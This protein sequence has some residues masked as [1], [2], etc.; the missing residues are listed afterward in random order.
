[1]SDDRDMEL[2]TALRSLPT[3]EHEPAFWA[4]LD[5]RLAGELPMEPDARAVRRFRPRGMWL[6]TAAAVAAVAVAAVAVI[7]GGTGTNVRVGPPATTPPTAPWTKLSQS[8][9]SPRWG[10]AAV[11]TGDAMVVWGGND[12]NAQTLEDGAVYDPAT[13]RWTSMA[14]APTGLFAPTAVW[15]GTRALF[16]G[17]RE[18]QGETA[19][20]A[21]VGALYDPVADTW[22]LIS[23]TPLRSVGQTVVWTGDALLVW[24]GSIGESPVADGAAYHPDTDTWTTMARAPIP[25][26]FDHTAV[27][28]GDRMIVW[29]GFAGEESPSRSAFADGAAYDPGT[30]SW[31]ALPAAPLAARAEHVAVWTGSSMVIWGGTTNASGLVAD[32][33]AYDPAAQSWT[34]LPPAPPALRPLRMA[35]TAVVAGGSVLV[36]GGNGEGGAVND[37][38]AYDVA[39]GAW[40]MLPESPLLPR[41][42]HSAVWTGSDMLVWGGEDL[43]V[44]R[45]D[46]AALRPPP[47]GV[48]GPPVTGDTPATQPPRAT[49][50]ALPATPCSDVVFTPDSED[51]AGN[52]VAEGISCDQA[53]A[54]IRRVG[55]ALP[56]TGGP[57]ELDQS[58]SMCVRTA[59]TDEGVPSA[60]Y[61]CTGTGRRITFVRT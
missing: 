19:D 58:G 8:P 9:L 34:V 24:G 20:A 35:P 31:A 23:P 13:D 30:D 5:G 61:E 56:A 57:A 54:F 47:A 7:D 39:A 50:A 48:P 40:R 52:I 14:P 36:W 12:Q 41:G 44:V 33:A 18:G 60:S 38:A 2:G 55:H 45:S 1:M 46:G 37:G 15:T 25:A 53:E 26:R 51:M 43:P 6:L 27:W 11:W 32:G 28:T 29:G 3:P 10:H 16:W 22:K 17:A 21:G 4:E 59:L 49:P 42:G